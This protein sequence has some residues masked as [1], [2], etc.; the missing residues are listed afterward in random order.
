LKITFKHGN[1]Q[2]AIQIMREA[3]QWLIDIDQPNWKLEDL[4]EK[5]MLQQNS[6][7]NFVV[8]Y[9]AGKPAATMILGWEDPIF[10]PDIENNTS[11]FIHKLSA[12]RK[13]AGK[14]I[15]VKL[16]HYAEKKCQEKN[17]PYLRLDCLGKRSKLCEYYEK[18]GFKLVEKKIYGSWGETAFYVKK[19]PKKS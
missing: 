18:N 13:F 12:S 2:D 11:G 17:I 19:T 6:E 3:A 16:L 1:V 9:V 7:E 5:K 8:A 10:W 4:S 15:A 14:N